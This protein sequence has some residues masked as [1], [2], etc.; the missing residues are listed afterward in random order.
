MFRKILYL[1]F[2]LAALSAYGYVGLT[3]WEMPQTKKGISP[4][5]VRGAR[6]GGYTYYY[7]SYRGGK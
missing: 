7:G 3:G 5:G 2:A 4:Q 1:T 6:A